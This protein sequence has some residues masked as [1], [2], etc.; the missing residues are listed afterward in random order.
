MTMSHDATRAPAI[1][2]RWVV[3]GTSEAAPSSTVA[4]G[5]K[6][7]NLLELASLASRA[8]LEVAFDVPRFFVVTSDAFERWGGSGAWPATE[9]EAAA[10][11]AEL[12][13][14]RWSRPGCAA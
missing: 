6:G 3:D 7:R 10:R 4:V 13:R 5:G 8:A 11:R 1:P 14:M 9:S 2:G 12:E